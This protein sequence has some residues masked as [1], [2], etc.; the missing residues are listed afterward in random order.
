ME[1]SQ[2][3]TFGPTAPGGD[4]VQK[5][6]AVGFPLLLLTLYLNGAVRRWFVRGRGGPGSFSI[7]L[8]SLQ[9]GKRVGMV[10]TIGSQ[11]FFSSLRSSRSFGLRF[12]II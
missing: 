12:E 5:S 2:P 10:Y 3:S 7:L 1:T 4:A 11:L 6:L 8:V 9:E